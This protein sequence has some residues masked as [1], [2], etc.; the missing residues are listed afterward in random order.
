MF[1]NYVLRAVY[2]WASQLPWTKVNK[3]SFTYSLDSD[4]SVVFFH[5]FPTVFLPSNNLRKRF[6]RCLV[7]VESNNAEVPLALR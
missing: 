5:H 2:G 3:R 4:Q 7:T 1:V 6:E